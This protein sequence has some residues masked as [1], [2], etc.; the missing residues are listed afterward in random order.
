MDFLS[1]LGSLVLSSS[2]LVVTWRS[3]KPTEIWF[4][5]DVT[6][7]EDW[8]TH[9]LTKSKDLNWTKPQMH[10]SENRTSLQMQQNY[11]PISQHGGLCRLQMT[12]KPIITHRNNPL[13][14]LQHW[15]SHG[16]P[17]CGVLKPT[18]TLMIAL[19]LSPHHSKLPLWTRVFP[20]ILP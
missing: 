5:Q 16:H 11:H 15:L 13:I 10:W 9:Y 8:V 18:L 14:A 20:A 4:V 2:S 7:I 3:K 12:N 17:H 6:V 1:G 19:A